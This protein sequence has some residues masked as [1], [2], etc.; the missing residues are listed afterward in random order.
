MHIALILL[1]ILCTIT[2]T[3][4]AFIESEMLGFILAGVTIATGCAS[5]LVLVMGLFT[6]IKILQTN[7]ENKSLNE[8]NNE[9]YGLIQ[10]IVNLFAEK[11]EKIQ[12]ISDKARNDAE[13]AIQSFEEMRE[14]FDLVVAGQKLVRE[15][16]K[17]NSNR[18][19][20][21]LKEI[22][23]SSTN[24][25]ILRDF[26]KIENDLKLLDSTLEQVTKFTDSG[27]KSNI[28]TFQT[29]AD[30]IVSWSNDL[31]TGVSAI[32]SQHKLLLSYINKLHRAIQ[33]YRDEQE[34]L[35]ILDALAGYAFTHFNTE[36]I[37]FTHSEYPLIDQH[38]AIHE[39]FKTK[40]VEF[41]KSVLEGKANVDTQVLDF[42]KNWLVE[43]I[44]GMDVGFGKYLKKGPDFSIAI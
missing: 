44:Q 41:R 23:E 38:I 4:S 11:A 26:K 20:N 33:N 1:I 16:I 6:P 40:V 19:K 17:T 37:F 12:S 36:E 42:L 9:S 8:F 18:I 7:F 29:S 21:L 13:D 34:L 14:K 5:I 31:S 32:D 28:P 2:G 10:D 43:H 15:N 27:E 24:A 30:N 39:E 22:P 25:V 35:D 3:T